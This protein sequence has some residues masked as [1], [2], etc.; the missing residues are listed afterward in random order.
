MYYLIIFFVIFRIYVL[1]NLSIIISLNA[2]NININEYSEKVFRIIFTNHFK[3]IS[4][5]LIENN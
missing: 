4:F 2:Y 3:A 1:F 5:I